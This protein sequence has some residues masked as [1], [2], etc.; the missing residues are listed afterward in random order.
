MHSISTA[1]S[2][3]RQET[4][5]QVRAGIALWSK[6]YVTIKRNKVESASDV[7][8]RNIFCKIGRQNETVTNLSVHLI[9]CSKVIFHISQID[10]DFDDVGEVRFGCFEDFL[11]V[12][13][14][15]ALLRKGKGKRKKENV[16]HKHG[17]NHD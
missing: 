7:K 16:K 14:G 15:G 11:D 2:K 12:F 13:E 8:R 9:H 10:V 1:A 4:P 6:N 5:T 3:G 17:H